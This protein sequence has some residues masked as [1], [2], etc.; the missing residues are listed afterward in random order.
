M[1]N[2]DSPHSLPASLA[3]VAQPSDEPA[4]HHEEPTFADILRQ[5]ERDYLTTGAP[6][7]PAEALQ[8]TVITVSAE[9]VFVDIGRKIEGVLSLDQYKAAAGKESVAPGD[10]VLV[11]VTGRNEEGYYLLSGIRITRPRDWSGLELAFAEKKTIAGTVT[12]LVKG[13]L[14]V[15]VGIPA[16]MPASRSGIRELADMEKLI[17]QEIQCRIIKLDTAGED[18]V[19]D[20]RVVIEEEEA[21]SK[22]RRFS[23]LQEGAVVRGS[24]RSL[25]DFGAFIDLGGVDGLLHVTDMSWRR[26]GK[27]GDIVSVGDSVEVMVLKVNPET[28]KISLGMKQ[29]VPDPWT[30]AVEQFKVGDRVRGKV[31]RLTDFGAFVELAPGVD[32]LIH[33]SELSWSR[34]IRKASD[35]VNAGEAVEVLVLGINLAEK[36]IALGLK[37]ALGDPWEEIDRRFPI[38]AVVE[39]PV[40]SL[41]KFGVFVDLGDGIEGMIHISDITSEKRLEHPKEKLAN[42]QV[43]KAQILEIDRE[44]RRIRLG[45]KQ[46]EPTSADEFIAGHQI[47]ATVT[48]RIVQ[49]GRETA[50]VELGEGVFAECRLKKPEAPQPPAAPSASDVASL[51]AMLSAKWKEGKSLSGAAQAQGLRAGE[52]RSFRITALDPAKKKIDLELA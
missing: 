39:G 25:T 16:F 50:K 43:V 48:G 1:S 34:K 42:R 52:I 40:V 15:D 37:Q 28:R 24:V 11:T 38:G 29:L 19:V 3:P 35:V 14:R 10:P 21:R 47:G 33:V 32:G 20:R 41:Q 4:P 30:L 5:F 17:G 51:S 6:D 18:V 36:R 45:M 31:V 46:L 9:A 27:P 7:K 23:E 44:R 2:P 8:G 49:V 26:V 13:G 12:E 22:E